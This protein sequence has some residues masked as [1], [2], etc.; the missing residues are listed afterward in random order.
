V[1]TPQSRRLSLDVPVVLSGYGR[2]GAAYAGQLCGRADELERRHGVRLRLAAVRGSAAECLVEDGHVPPRQRWR[3][4]RPLAELL[5]ETGATVF[6]QAIPSSP[7]ALGDAEQDALTALHGGADLVTATKSH[8]LAAWSTLA[9]AAAD[10]GRR[11]RISG[12]TGAALPAGDLARVSLRGF[13]C[14]TIRACPNGTSTFVLDRLAAG[15]TLAEAVAEAQRRGIAEADPSADLSGRDAATKVRLLAGLLWDWNVTATET[16]L[17]PLTE[18]AAEA[19][20]GAASR[21]ARLRA[22]AAARE[23]MPG[24][25]R[26]TLE[27]TTPGDPLYALIG[28]EK[29]VVYDCGE[30]GA[31][32]VSGGRSSPLGAAL[33][34][35]KDTLDVATARTARAFD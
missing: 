5:A 19:A 24:I 3:P 13:G 1:S 20:R 23:D 28:P 25:V 14:R 35:L 21:G 33:A 31:V 15:E 18:G 10:A 26:V 17:T 29:A 6:A 9:G 27:P 2:V 16:D 7:Q 34:M 8:L 11:I 22:I 4:A 12:A 30:A 32:T